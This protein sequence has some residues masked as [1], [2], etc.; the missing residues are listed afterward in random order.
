M[1]AALSGCSKLMP[2]LDEVL[3]DNRKDYQKAQKGGIKQMP[4]VVQASRALQSAQEGVRSAQEGVRQSQDSLAKATENL[5]YLTEL[6]TLRW[7]R[8]VSGRTAEELG[9]LELVAAGRAAES[10]T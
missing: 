8:A 2:K 6:V 7:F 9:R 5:R 1:A 3:P 4:Q 10:E